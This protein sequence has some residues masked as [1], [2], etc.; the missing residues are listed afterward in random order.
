MSEEL[1]EF[2]RSIPDSGSYSTS[3]N[4]WKPSFINNMTQLIHLV[5]NEKIF[6]PSWSVKTDEQLLNAV[7]SDD[8]SKVRF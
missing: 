6:N 4:E 8:V 5:D 3:F 2:V 7:Q 1:K